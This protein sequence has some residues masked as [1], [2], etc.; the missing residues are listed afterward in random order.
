MVVGVWNQTKGL[1]ERLLFSWL[2]FLAFEHIHKASLLLL[3]SLS[4][5]IEDRAHTKKIKGIQDLTLR[6][7]LYA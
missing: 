3:P 6:S 4:L 7:F 2:T 5:N 1:S